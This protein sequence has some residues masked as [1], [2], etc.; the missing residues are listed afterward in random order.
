VQ[1]RKRLCVVWG[2]GRKKEYQV[3]KTI[4]SDFA[5]LSH[6]DLESGNVIS[7]KNKYRRRNT[8]TQGHSTAKRGRIIQI[9]E[10]QVKDHLG[11]IVRGTVQETLN[12]LLDEEAERLCRARRYERTDERKDTRA[13]HYT[14]KLHTKAGEVDIK[15]PKLRVLP[16]ETAIMERCRRRESSV[17]EALVEMYLAGVSVRRVEDIT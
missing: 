12:T 17:E 15:M 8:M 1:E 2:E 14:R 7:P 10:E 3:F 5:Q 16:F 11:E 13:G 4:A 6:G 9:D